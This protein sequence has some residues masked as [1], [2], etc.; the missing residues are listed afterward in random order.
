MEFVLADHFYVLAEEVVV[1]GGSGGVGGAGDGAGF[2]ALW[3]RL[4]GGVFQDTRFTGKGGLHV[5]V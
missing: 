1:G 3:V 5:L 4:G 2:P